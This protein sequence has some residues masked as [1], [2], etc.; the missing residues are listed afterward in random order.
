[1]RSDP[2][3][4]SRRERFGPGPAIAN[5]VPSEAA[6]RGA[7]RTDP[8]GGAVADALVLSG[9]VRS[10]DGTGHGF[11]NHRGGTDVALE[12]APR[13]PDDG[14]AAPAAF[15]VGPRRQ[16]GGER[17]DAERAGARPHER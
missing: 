14:D 11:Q 15:V 5:R 1:M 8:L 16:R 12:H 13:A 10:R 9:S 4:D 3:P 6:H 7:A 2:D 17:P